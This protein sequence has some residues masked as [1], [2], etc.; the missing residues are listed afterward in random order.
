RHLQRAGH[1]EA[2]PARAFLRRERARA[3]QE[4]LPVRSLA[5]AVAEHALPVLEEVAA[6]DAARGDDVAVARVHEPGAELRLAR[7]VHPPEA[8]DLDGVAVDAEPAAHP[9]TRHVQEER[10]ALAPAEAK[11]P[12]APYDAGQHPVEGQVEEVRLAS[13]AGG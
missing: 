9:R 4:K 8:R 12:V 10:H 6:L 1:G 2:A 13:L 11:G 3:Q 5:H 7:V